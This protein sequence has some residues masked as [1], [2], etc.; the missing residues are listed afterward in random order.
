MALQLIKPTVRETGLLHK[1]NILY[2]DIFLTQYIYILS[3]KLR[4]VSR[5][6]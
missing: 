5:I 6:F 1:I 3:Q 2:F 4:H